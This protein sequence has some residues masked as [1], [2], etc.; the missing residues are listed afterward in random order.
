MNSSIQSKIITIGNSRGIRIPRTI[1]E[2][3]GLEDNVELLVEGNRLIVQSI[4]ATR[5]GWFEQFAIMA[6]NKHDELVDKIPS[7]Q[8]DEEE[9]TW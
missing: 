1:I 6:K 5:K 7:T 9:W 2:Q 8:W 3:I 4:S